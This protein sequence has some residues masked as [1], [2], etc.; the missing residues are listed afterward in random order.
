MNEKCGTMQHGNMNVK[1][2]TMQHGNM[3]VKLF[4]CSENP[5]QVAES[6]E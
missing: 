5:Q 1:G 4:I 6:A 3:N 2:G